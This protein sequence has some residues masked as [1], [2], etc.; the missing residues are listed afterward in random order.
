MRFTTRTART[1]MTRTMTRA[2]AWSALALC[3]LVGC[4]GTEKPGGSASATVTPHVSIPPLPSVESATPLAPDTYRFSVHVNDGVEAPGANI[5]VPSG[6]GAG[7]DWFVVL[8]DGQEHLGLWTVRSGLH[9]P[10]RRRE[11]GVRPARPG[12]RSAT[13]PR[14]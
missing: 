3:L 13:S 8:P 1:T 6:F 12:R 4:S 9:R 2:T 7:S 10:V 11:V 14:R 5:A